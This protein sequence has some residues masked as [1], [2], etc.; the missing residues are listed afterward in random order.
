MTKRGANEEFLSD[1]TKRLD[2]QREQILASLTP[3][4]REVLKTLREGTRATVAAAL[5]VAGSPADVSDR[6]V[7]SHAGGPRVSSGKGTSKQDYHTPRE[8]LGKVEAR[9]GSIRFDLAAD[10]KNCVVGPEKTGPRHYSKEDSAFI[11]DWN[12][13]PIRPDEE[14]QDLLWLNPPFDNIA[15]FA[16]KCADTIRAAPAGRWPTRI[17]LLVP[18][19]VGSNWF[20]DHVWEKSLVLF[21]NGRIC[22]DS[23]N[24]Y[25]KD[26]M[27][28]IYD[29][30]RIRPEPPEVWSWKA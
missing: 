2:A 24:P 26:C 1:L 30:T 20:R 18:A 6:V 14:W 4:E 16:K 19:S 13:D 23:K 10:A 27:L 8:F 29:A 28:A 12:T 3:K 5:G 22:F 21:L 7:A 25:P 15:P 11:H 17:A 9:F